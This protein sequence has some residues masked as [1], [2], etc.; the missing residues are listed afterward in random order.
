MGGISARAKSAAASVMRLQKTRGAD[1]IVSDSIGGGFGILPHDSLS[2]RHL[3]QAGRARPTA[4]LMAGS[5]LPS[6]LQPYPQPTGE[7]DPEARSQA[8][9]ESARQ[10]CVAIPAAD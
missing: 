9:P 10:T 1:E 6:R 2:H 8:S 3:R 7:T 5:Y 4:R